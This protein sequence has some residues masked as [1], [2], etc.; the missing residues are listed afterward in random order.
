M[1]RSLKS[2][3]SAITSLRSC[4]FTKTERDTG[5]VN[6]ELTRSEASGTGEGRVEQE[7]TTDFKIKQDV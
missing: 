2:S 3:I 1:I 5:K 7:V 4:F 6:Q